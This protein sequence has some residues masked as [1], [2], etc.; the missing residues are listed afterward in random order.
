MPYDW[1]N[2]PNDNFLEAK[3]FAHGFY[4]TI[5]R[6][7]C[8]ALNDEYIAFNAKG[9]HHV[10]NKKSRTKDE[11]VARLSYLQYVESIISD[12]FAK[13]DFRQKKEKEY[14]KKNGLYQLYEVVSQYWTF[15]KPIDA[16]LKIKVVIRQVEQGG[17]YF[18]SIM[19]YEHLNTTKP[20]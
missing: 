5:G 3:K 13:I 18:Y 19:K 17:K 4:S 20:Q 7:K 11:V 9:I 8:P 16:T 10:I 1:N 2:F 14:L 12:P 6:I 15:T